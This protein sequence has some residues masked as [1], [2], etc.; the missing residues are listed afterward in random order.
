MKRRQS[1]F[2]LI[3]LM[4]VVTIIGI[5]ASFAIPAYQDYTIRAQVSEGLSLSTIARAAVA[6]EFLTE[7]LPPTDRADAGM[8]ADP[9]D[10]SGRYVSGVDITD[11]V[12]TIAY[13]NEAN[14][15]IAEAGANT[16][17]MTP[18]ESSDLSL[19]WRMRFRAGA[20]RCGTAGHCSRDGG[21]V[22]G[23]DT[24]GALPAGRMPPVRV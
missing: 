7:G 10:T 16:L 15:R 24:G 4:V 12:L 21:D 9:A 2:T 5:L 17:T 19:L 14:A 3:E 18:Y 8:S 6:E 22:P 20:G 1:G 23:A 13:G 11:G